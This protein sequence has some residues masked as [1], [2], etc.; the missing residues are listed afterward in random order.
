MTN[1]RAPSGHRIGAWH[2]KAKY[3]DAIIAEVRKK[4]IPH[5]YGIKRLSDEFDIPYS[6]VRDW[7]QY[8]TRYA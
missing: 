8:K 4:H 5:V 6:T 7:V 1:K 2:G 3:S